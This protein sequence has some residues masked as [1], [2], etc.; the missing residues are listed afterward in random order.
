M[1]SR[2]TSSSRIMWRKK[3]TYWVLIFQAKGA[4]LFHV[5]EASA[6]GIWVCRIPCPSCHVIVGPLWPLS[7]SPVGIHPVSSS[8]TG[9]NSP[10]SHAWILPFVRSSP[11]RGISWRE[12]LGCPELLPNVPY[13]PHKWFWGATSTI[14]G[15]RWCQYPQEKTLPC[16]LDLF[17]LNAAGDH[18]LT[19]ARE[20]CY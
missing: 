9:S 4:D 12:I 18:C 16:D 8:L 14:I 2:P 7:S 17:P 3:L 1:L 20:P 10:T 6:R 15:E 11:F 19:N 13:V 5:T